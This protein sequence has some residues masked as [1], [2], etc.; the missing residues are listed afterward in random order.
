M[1][2]RLLNEGEER[3]FV[4]VFDTGD[5]VLSGLGG[6]ARK[7]RIAAAEFTGIGAFSGVALGYFDWQ[8]KEYRRIPIAEQ[9]EVVSLLGNIACGEDG[10]P[11]LHPHIVVA[12]ADGSAHGGH[13]LEGRVR[14]TL[15]LVV[16]EAPAHLQRRHDP[17]SGLALIRL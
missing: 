11:M 12:K 7:H 15:E 8:R 17:Q 6:F 4:L 16:T 1:R 3:S 13:L 5:E 14:P 9:V 10:E 2:S